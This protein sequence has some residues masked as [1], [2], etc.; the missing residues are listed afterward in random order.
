MSPTRELAKQNH[1]VLK[2]LASYMKLRSH[3]LIGGIST[4]DDIDILQ[5]EELPHVIVGTPG[6]IQ[7][8]LYNNYINTQNINKIILDE[9]DEMLSSGFNEQVYNI[10]QYLK[11]DVQVGLFS[12]T[13]PEQVKKLTQKFMIEPITIYVDREMLTLEG[14]KQYY[15]GLNDDI[16]KYDTLKDLFKTLA[17][18]QTIIYCNSVNRVQNLFEAMKQDE[19]PVVCIHSGMN[20][21]ERSEAF[22]Q[23]KSGKYRVLISSDVT[24]R[25]IDVQQVSIVI[26][27]D[28]CKNIST[29]LHRIGRSARWGRKGIAIN[30]VTKRDISKLKEIETFY[31]T[32]I[33]E[34]PTNFADSLN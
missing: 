24:S 21:Q 10:F 15:I 32:S 8:M 16:E 4:K 22:N 2:N 11:N 13:M 23:F 6:R 33:D 5:N 31:N 27:F 7:Y 28:I 26:N 9:A 3:L 30:F 12:A 17:L 1:E 29:Y 18:S 34:L 14:L 20:N 25:G 19:F